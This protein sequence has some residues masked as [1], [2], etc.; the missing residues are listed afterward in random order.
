MQ[1]DVSEFM[2]LSESIRYVEKELTKISKDLKKED[3]KESDRYIQLASL[4][5]SDLR[6]IAKFI[7]SLRKNS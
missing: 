7:N 1:K 2:R 6:K 4:I 5:N 3:K